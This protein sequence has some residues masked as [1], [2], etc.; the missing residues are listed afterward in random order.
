MTVF[1]QIYDSFDTKFFKYK[2]AVL[3]GGHVVAKRSPCLRPLF[4]LPLSYI[5]VPAT[6]VTYH[7]GFVGNSNKITLYEKSPE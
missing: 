4:L 1:Y 2:K 6:K 3:S 5:N 7:Q